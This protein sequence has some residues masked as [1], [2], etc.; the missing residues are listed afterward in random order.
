MELHNYALGLRNEITDGVQAVVERLK[1]RREELTDENL[2]AYLVTLDKA[3]SILK[4]IEV[5]VPKKTA[6][7]KDEESAGDGEIK[8]LGNHKLSTFQKQQLKAV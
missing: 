5:S 1:K 7:E 3:A 8:I 4:K 6:K 2:D